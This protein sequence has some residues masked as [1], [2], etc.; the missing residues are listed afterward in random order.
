[1]NLDEYELNLLEKLRKNKYVLSFVKKYHV[2]LSFVQR[3]LYDINEWVKTLEKCENCKGMEFCRQ[4]KQGCIKN[5]YVDDGYLDHVFVSCT[6]AKKKKQAI[7]HKKNYRIS[8]L[9][10]EEYLIDINQFDLHL[11]NNEYLKAYMSVTD[12]YNQ[13]KGIY[14]YG[15]PGVGKTYLMIA[16]AN[17]YA[18]EG[19]KVSFVKVPQLVQEYRDNMTDNDYTATMMNNL[20]FSEILFLDDIGSEFISQWTRDNLLFPILNYRMDHG[21]KTY[22]TSNYTLEELEQQYYIKGKDENRVPSN[23]MMERIKS[24]SLAQSMLGKSRR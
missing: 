20:K 16:L 7:A 11:E 23:R 21:L 5:I 17:K 9:S 8:D 6:F 12:S 2:D 13:D 24:L 14:L 15:Q 22:F 18:K 4:N 1:M 19:K 10:D 3:N